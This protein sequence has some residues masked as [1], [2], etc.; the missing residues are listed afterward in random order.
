MGNI[1]TALCNQ[2]ISLSQYNKYF[3]WLLALLYSPKSYAQ[4][5][6]W[7]HNFGSSQIDQGSSITVDDAGNI[8]ATGLFWGTADFDP[9]PGIYYLSS[10]GLMDIYIC[11]LD[12]NGNFIW[13]KALQGS[14]GGGWVSNGDSHITVDNV[15]N[16][17]VVGTFSDTTDFDPG[18]AIHTLSPAGM[19]LFILKLTA[20][21]DFAWAKQIA[22]KN[23][24]RHA[25]IALGNKDDF[26]ITGTFFD[27]ADFDPGPGQYT[28]ITP[29]HGENGFIA[30]FNVNGNFLW[31]KMLGGNDLVRSASISVER[32][33]NVSVMGE[34]FGTVDLDPGPGQFTRTSVGNIDIF[35]CK[36]NQDGNF[37]FGLSFGSSVFDG[38]GGWSLIAQVIYM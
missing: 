20:S 18:T 30:K 33:N 3:F 24:L 28:L 26:Y 34:F 9:G 7:M 36:L 12:P 25:R 8:Y 35:L 6:G 22:G 10:A 23:S 5:F 2:A 38:V 16:I 32:N 19:D 14:S 15:G 37:V 21:G 13:A 1:Q 31:A 17:Y 11:K 29:I 27:T 4:Y